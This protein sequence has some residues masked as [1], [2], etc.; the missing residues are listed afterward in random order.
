VPPASS[1]TNAAADVTD[2]GR[3]QV[4]EGEPVNSR[5][6]AELADIN[7]QDVSNVFDSGHM[8]M[9]PRSAQ[10]YYYEDSDLRQR[11]FGS[12]LSWV[13]DSP[14]AQISGRLGLLK[15]FAMEH[16]VTPALRGLSSSFWTDKQ[17]RDWIRQCAKT[18][19]P[20]FVVECLSVIRMKNADMAIST[21]IVAIDLLF[22]MGHADIGMLYA[23]EYFDPH[24]LPA[25]RAVPE[26]EMTS[27][28]LRALERELWEAMPKDFTTKAL[29]YSAYHV[30]RRAFKQYLLL[31][32]EEKADESEADDARL[33][34]DLGWRI[35]KPT[36]EGSESTPVS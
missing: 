29:E 23:F 20:T 35:S 26:T 14:E 31:H 19:D 10:Q 33:Y 9:Q 1:L 4:V 30:M 18:H 6:K 12:V 24:V 13:T 7:T 16:Y 28:K 3:S 11:M 34:D 21:R 8:V 17:E 32:F 5:G 15:D 22:A 27:R 25:L 2:P 36:P